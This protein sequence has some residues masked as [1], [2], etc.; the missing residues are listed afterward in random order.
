MTDAVAVL[1]RLQ[2]LCVRLEVEQSEKWEQLERK[3]ELL[4]LVME[5]RSCL[6]ALPEGIS[7]SLISIAISQCELLD[8]TSNKLAEELPRIIR[9]LG[10]RFLLCD[11]TFCSSHQ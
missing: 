11:P 2:H 7:N 4:F 8:N 6:D 1:P 3:I 5:S 10:I 9:M